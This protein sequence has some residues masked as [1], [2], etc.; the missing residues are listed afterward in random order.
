MLPLECCTLDLV[1]NQAIGSF[2]LFLSLDG[3]LVAVLAL[4][5]RRCNEGVGGLGCKVGRRL[6]SGQHQRIQ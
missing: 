3:G 5:R 1:R 4:R 6:G 2:C